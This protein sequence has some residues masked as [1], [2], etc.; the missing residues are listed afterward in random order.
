M[1]DYFDEGPR[2]DIWFDTNIKK[3]HHSMETIVGALTENNY[4]IE[5]LL[6]PQP[7]DATLKQFPEMIKGKRYPMFLAISSIK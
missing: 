6:E 2:E 7:Q 3:F 5:K 1:D 4:K